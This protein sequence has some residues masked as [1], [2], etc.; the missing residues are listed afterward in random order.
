MANSTTT[1]PA[2]GPDSSSTTKRRV[3]SLRLSR[4]L[5]CTRLGL[6]TAGNIPFKHQLADH[7]QFPV[8][9]WEQLIHIY[10]ALSLKVV[11]DLDKT[12]PMEWHD[13]NQRRTPLP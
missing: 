1:R 9:F 7:R 4:P 2:L 13:T 11:Y 3:H 6:Q 10:L 12:R 5:P 8:L